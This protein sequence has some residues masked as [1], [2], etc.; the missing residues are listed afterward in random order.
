MYDINLRRDLIIGFHV[1]YIIVSHFSNQS[2]FLLHVS[3]MLHKG[4]NI[5][6]RIESKRDFYVFKLQNC[7]SGQIAF[8]HKQIGQMMGHLETDNF[9]FLPD[10]RGRISNLSTPLKSQSPITPV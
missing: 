10:V 2:S 1:S 5:L 8:Q 9:R 7:G 6:L 4:L 3:I